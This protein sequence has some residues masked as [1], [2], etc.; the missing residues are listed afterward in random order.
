[1]PVVE[2]SV[3]VGPPESSKSVPALEEVKVTDVVCDTG[4]ARS[5][6]VNTSLFSNEKLLLTVP[7]QFVLLMP[8]CVNTKGIDTPLISKGIIWNQYSL[9]GLVLERA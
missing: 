4:F 3:M 9:Y 2:G 1:M 8:G 7:P 6:R 5:R